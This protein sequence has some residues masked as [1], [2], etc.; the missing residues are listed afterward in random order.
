ME[1]VKSQTL[2][3]SPF[4]AAKDELNMAKQAY[5]SSLSSFLPEVNFFGSLSERDGGFAIVSDIE[6]IKNIGNK[7]YDYGLTAKMSLFSGFSDYNKMRSLSAKA[8]AA[9]ESYRRSVCDAVCDAY[10]AYVTS[11]EAR[12]SCSSR[13]RPT[14]NH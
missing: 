4:I 5:R 7:K 11:R 10:S 6:T 14:P 8:K 13:N 2:D 1:I 12:R 9:E 3:N